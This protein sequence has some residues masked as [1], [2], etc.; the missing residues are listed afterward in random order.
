[1]PE[2][3]GFEFCKK[4][5][6]KERRIELPISSNL[7]DCKRLMKE[8]QLEGNSGL[9]LTDYSFKPFKT[10]QLDSKGEK[11]IELQAQLRLRYPTEILFPQKELL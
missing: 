9:A 7:A 4:E 11:L 2:M 1:M 5:K 3:D 8:A 6:D 10:N